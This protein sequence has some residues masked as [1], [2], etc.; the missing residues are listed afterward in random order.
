MKNTIWLFVLI[1]SS[2]F[3][4]CEK[5]E[6]IPGIVKELEFVCPDGEG[7]LSYFEGVIDDNK[8]CYK[9]EVNGYR[10]EIS[11]TAGFR[12]DGPTTSSTVDPNAVSNYRV[13]GNL[14]FMPK[15]IWNNQGVGTIP[16]LKHY[17]LLETPANPE[18]QPLSEMIFDNLMEVGDL[19]IQS[20]KVG[21]MEGFNIVFRFNDAESHVSQIFETTGGKQDDSYLKITELEK[22]EY[23]N[24]THYEVTFEFS[25]NLYYYGDPK[26]LYARLEDGKMKLQFEI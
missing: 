16:H 15:A 19:P 26:K 6:L 17:V 10:I 1:F 4:G 24:G 3:L 21:S 14:G 7:A 22:T 18:S 11:Q 8:F 23:P 9:D 5:E 13:W 12:T 2:L 25:C 20:N